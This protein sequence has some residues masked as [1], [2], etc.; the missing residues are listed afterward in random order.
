MTSSSHSAIIGDM[1]D[2]YDDMFAD[3]MEQGPIEHDDMYDFESA[4][5]SAGFGTDEWYGDYGA[6]EGYLYDE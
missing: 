1:E 4:L 5:G 6:E 2:E 3:D